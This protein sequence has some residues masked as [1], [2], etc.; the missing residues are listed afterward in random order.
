M[1]DE[2]SGVVIVYNG[3]IYNYREL[4]EQL[5]D[6]VFHS[7]S[8]T[9]VI[10]RL[11]LRHGIACV[12][13]LRGMFAFVIWDPHSH[14]LHLCRDRFGIKPL[15]YHYDGD[16]LAFAS[17]I[18]GLLALGVPAKLN[19]R[20]VYDYLR[21]GLT[22]HTEDTFFENI[23]SLEPGIVLSLQNGIMKKTA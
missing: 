10:L 18:K 17:E 20:T 14:T 9:E 2:A 5:G 19:R 13:M 3:E 8:D 23:R 21:S 4:K 7:Q 22:A 15:Y 12:G 6:E 1:K 16:T 11:Y